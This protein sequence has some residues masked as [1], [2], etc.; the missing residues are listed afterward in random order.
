MIYLFFQARFQLATLKEDIKQGKYNILFDINRRDERQTALYRLNN[1]MRYGDSYDVI[2]LPPQEDNTL[3][4]MAVFKQRPD[5]VS[6]DDI[7]KEEYEKIWKI[8][9]VTYEDS[10]DEN[11]MDY[12]AMALV[13]DSVKY[14]SWEE[15]AHLIN[16]NYCVDDKYGRCEEYSLCLMTD[17]RFK[18]EKQ[19][20][21]RWNMRN[22]SPKILYKEDAQREAKKLLAGPD[23]MA[24]LERIYDPNNVQDFCGIPVHYRITAEN[25][26]VAEK[27]IDL[28]VGALYGKNRIL[29]DHITHIKIGSDESN[30]K[31]TDEDLVDRVMKGSY[32]CV[33]VL[34]L[35]CMNTEENIRAVEDETREYIMKNVL[36]YHKD[37]VFIFL[38]HSDRE[39]DIDTSDRNGRPVLKIVNLNEGYGTREQA[40]EIFRELAEDSE[41]AQYASEE[42]FEEMMSEKTQFTCS[43]IYDSFEHWSENVM[44]NKAYSSY[45]NLQTEDE[46]SVYK[47]I[48]RDN[49]PYKELQEMVGLEKAK[50]MIDDILMGQEMRALKK[51]RGFKTNK[52]SNHILFT[53]NPGCAKTTVARLIARIL[54]DRKVISNPHLVECGRSNLVA[55]YVG[56]T[57]IQVRK[58]FLKASGG[59]LFIDEAYSLVDG[60]RGSFGDE[61]IATIV[62]EMENMR[63]SVIV[64]FAGYKQPMERF[65]QANEGLRSR[66]GYHVDFPDYN[67]D[68]LTA[69]IK[70]MASQQKYVISGKAI[71]RCHEIFA[72]ACKNEEFGNGRF[73]RNV[74]EQAI[75]H[76]ARRILSAHRNDK[77]SIT[78]K[79]LSQLE[80]EDFDVNVA[81]QYK[82]QSRLGIGFMG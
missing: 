32:G 25:D 13:K 39:G 33:V 64:I 82:K 62:Q 9:K 19:M 60:Y 6:I 20:S 79:E 12:H 69:I 40:E 7:L 76:Q 26:R 55:K 57:A 53:G 42:D 74:L 52:G 45:R 37:T 50:A 47:H 75:L 29:S 78:D 2:C 10:D 72:Q 35:N 30:Y 23:F 14:L 8:L 18:N 24:E 48:E 77:D 49:D 81:D 61:A 51:S 58:L 63:N 4:M 67:A 66:I 36:K 21:L 65:L 73:A 11:E 71:Q 59:V 31:N 54:Y 38:K 3:D 41:F 27:Y 70:L 80:L 15:A 68:E 46:V 34:E 5:V 16:D 1:M 28:L 44:K 43:D 56:N 17:K 22:C